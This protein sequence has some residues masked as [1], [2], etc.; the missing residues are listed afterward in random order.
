MS[1][2]KVVVVGSG[3]RVREAALPALHRLADRYE[4]AGVFARTAKRLE[5]D[6]RAYDV[7]PFDGFGA[8]E[9]AGTDLL[10][11]AV[12]KDAVPRVLDRLAA[13][14][15][16]GV[17]VLIDTPV[18]RFKH[19]RHAAKLRR[20]RSAWVAEDCVELPW[21]PLVREVVAAGAIGALRGVLFLQ[22]AYAYHGVA[23]A[24]A[25]LGADRVTWGRRASLGGR[26]GLRTLRLR[27][28]A[29]AWIVEPRDY[30]TG[31]LV[32]TGS[33]ASISDYPQRVDGNLLLAPAVEGGRCTGLR[34]GDAA[35]ALSDAESELMGEGD[36][37]APL[38]AWMDPMKRVGFLRLL[39]RIADGR[40]GYPVADALD[41]MAVDYHLEKVGLYAANPLTSTRS[42]LARALLSA[43]TR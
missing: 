22:S 23:V 16:S 17:D 18:V 36:P 41:D 34:L 2:R 3:K 11:L 13:L 42:P 40:G 7:A 20:F 38:T 32:V 43:V 10:Y 21:I 33:R 29:R 19:F 26:F 30:P 35:H 28:G 8:A 15:P 1:T 39:E 4:V 27:G 25:V 14:D 5:V 31:R 9:L 6:G 12:T 37:A 24:K